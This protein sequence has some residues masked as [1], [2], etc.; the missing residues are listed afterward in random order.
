M[1]IFSLNKNPNWQF[2]QK[3]H[4]YGKAIFETP[5]IILKSVEK[6]YSRFEQL[7]FW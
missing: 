1:T 5:Q 7:V 2:L 3:E 6:Q 4:L